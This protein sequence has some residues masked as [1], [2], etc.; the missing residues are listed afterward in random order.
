MDIIR[1]L[2]FD[3]ESKATPETRGM[4]PLVQRYFYLADKSERTSEEDEEMNAL[5]KEIDDLGLS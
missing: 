5:E 1:L 3:L 4:I 2:S